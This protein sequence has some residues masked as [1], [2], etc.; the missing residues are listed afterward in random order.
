MKVRRIC[1]RS[2]AVG[3]A[4]EN[5]ECGGKRSATALFLAHFPPSECYPKRRRASLAAALHIGFAESSS[6]PY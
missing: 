6:L 1:N 5:V 4:P 2:V 3:G